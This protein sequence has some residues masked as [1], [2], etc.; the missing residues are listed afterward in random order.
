M[1]FAVPN[2]FLGR[3][4]S[5][6]PGPAFADLQAVKIVD[7]VA[8]LTPCSAKIVASA[9]FTDTEGL[10]SWPAQHLRYL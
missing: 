9:A 4:S 8:F 2:T 10:K 1:H 7:S 5:R 6:F 3:P